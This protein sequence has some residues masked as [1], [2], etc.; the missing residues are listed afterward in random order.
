L[1]SG[2][3][4]NSI[5]LENYK[6]QVLRISFKEAFLIKMTTTAGDRI[7]MVAA[8]SAGALSPKSQAASLPFYCPQT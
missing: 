1:C 8:S 6:I 7:L 5:L 3:E 2:E 4:Y